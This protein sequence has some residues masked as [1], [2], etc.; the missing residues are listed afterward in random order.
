VLTVVPRL[1]WR[2][3]GRRSD[4]RQNTVYFGH[5]RHWDP[6]DLAAQLAAGGPPELPQLAAQLVAT[7]RIA[8]RKHAWLQ[9]SLAA[10]ALGIAC[11]L[12]V[13]LASR[14]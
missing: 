2:A 12:V 10:F 9:G 4:W 6:D 14:A 13:A 5:L 7:A 1:Q 3:C 8:W 11:L